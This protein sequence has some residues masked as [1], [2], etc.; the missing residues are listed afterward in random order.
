MN[1]DKTANILVVVPSPLGWIA[2]VGAGKLLKRLTFGHRN[3]A[4]AVR[5]L[6][7]KLSEVAVA[8][9]WNTELVARLQQYAAGKLVDFRDIRIDTREL[10]DFRRAVTLHCRRIGYGEVRTYGQLAAEAGYAGAARAVGSCMAA[11]RF[12]LI[13]P[14]HRVLSANGRLGGFS[15]PGGIALKERLLAMEAHK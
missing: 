4:A 7:P 9:T 8:G 6:E 1:R 12:P 5:A 2:L 15:A 10:T 14:C 13:V 11:N 3:R